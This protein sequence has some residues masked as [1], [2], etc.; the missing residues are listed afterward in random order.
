M[1]ARLHLDIIKMN[2]KNAYPEIQICCHS[3]VEIL[4][5]F[6]RDIHLGNFRQSGEECLFLTLC[7]SQTVCQKMQ[8]AEVC[9]VN[10]CVLEALEVKTF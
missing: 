10:T 4:K 7:Q 9:S 5:W 2:K 1:S 8:E 3:V 6:G